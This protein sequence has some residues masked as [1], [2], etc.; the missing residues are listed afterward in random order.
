VLF[1]T[2]LATVLAAIGLSVATARVIGVTK[3]SIKRKYSAING[4]SP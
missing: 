3:L 1:S 4:D 2:V